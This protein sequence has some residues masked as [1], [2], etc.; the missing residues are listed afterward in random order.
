MS[1]N[2][3]IKLILGCIIALFPVSNVQGK[4]PILLAGIEAYTKIEESLFNKDFKIFKEEKINIKEDE[5]YDALFTKFQIFLEQYNP[6]SG[7]KVNIKVTNSER[8]LKFELKYKLN[9]YR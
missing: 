3:V 5:Y 6:N 9:F 2:T 8:R 7:F 4:A 1:K